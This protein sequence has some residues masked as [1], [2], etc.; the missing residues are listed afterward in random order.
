MHNDICSIFDG[1]DNLKSWVYMRISFMYQL[2][3]VIRFHFLIASIWLALMRY[4]FRQALCLLLHN[5]KSMS[6]GVPM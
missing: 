6:Q 5:A 2:V 1:C 4:A 3:T